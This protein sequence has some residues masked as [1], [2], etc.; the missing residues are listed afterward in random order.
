MEQLV[1]FIEAIAWPFAII[2]L[3]YM[4][5]R[6]VRQLLGRMSTFKYKDMEANFEKELL[7][8]ETEAKKITTI[9]GKTWEDATARAVTTQFEQFQR[10][11]EI[12]PRAAIL[13]SWLDVEVAIMAAAEKAGLEVKA[14]VNITQLA[15]HLFAMGAINNEVVP[16]FQS[17]RN[18]RNQAAHMAEFTL[19]YEE[20]IKYL[21]L[22]LGVANTFRRYATA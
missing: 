3:A 2:W 12:S 21:N 17:I 20:A 18:L 6:E 8:A 9:E 1:K 16:V 4:F 10:I 19:S 7:K 11:A 15:K 5:R 22:A 14:P 13:E